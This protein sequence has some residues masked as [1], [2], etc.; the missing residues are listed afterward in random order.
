MHRTVELKSQPQGA[1]LSPPWAL[2]LASLDRLRELGEADLAFLVGLSMCRL[3]AQRRIVV[4]GCLH[5]QSVRLPQLAR[6]LALPLSLTDGCS[7]ASRLQRLWL[8]DCAI[9]DDGLAILAPAIGRG[10]PTLSHLTLSFNGFGSRGLNA[11]AAVAAAGQLRSLSECDVGGNRIDDVSALAAALANGQLRRLQWL[12]LSS[13]R[14]DDAAAHALAFA[15]AAGALPALQ[16]L[17]LEGNS[18]TPR[19]LGALEQTLRRAA[20]ITEDL[21]H[22]LQWCA[23]WACQRLPQTRAT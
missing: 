13:N 10:S 23:S 8:C 2:P 5:L 20:L 15:V 18:I 9:D 6:M 22:D 17:A 12:E 1:A 21:E 7:L 11:V 4:F 14:L 3:T 19:A 16:V